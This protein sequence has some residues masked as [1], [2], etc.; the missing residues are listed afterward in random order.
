MMP[1]VSTSAV[2]HH[3]FVHRLA[4]V[5]VK[6]FPVRCVFSIWVRLTVKPHVRPSNAP[7]WMENRRKGQRRFQQEAVQAGAPLRRVAPGGRV[8]I[9]RTPGSKREMDSLA[10]IDEKPA[11]PELAAASDDETDL[12][13]NDEETDTDTEVWALVWNVLLRRKCNDQD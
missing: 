7:E 1:L 6:V 12:D 5:F 13:A 11:A 10:P 8:D 3:P 9:S 2:F 4:G